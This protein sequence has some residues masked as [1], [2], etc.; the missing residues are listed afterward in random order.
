MKRLFKVKVETEIMVMAESSKEAIQTALK[1]ASGEIGIYG[2]GDATPI[3]SIIEIPEDWKGT[4]PY[5]PEG[6]QQETRKCYEVVSDFQKNSE[7]GL[8]DKDVQ[9]IIRIKQQSK[10]PLL[11]P[12]QSP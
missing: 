3:N 5:C 7:K 11:I 12:M 4:I 9:E 8:D 10:L 6:S 2:K 1:N